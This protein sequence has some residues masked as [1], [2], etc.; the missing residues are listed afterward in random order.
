MIEKKDEAKAEGAEA[1]PED[2]AAPQA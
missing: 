1:A 2:G